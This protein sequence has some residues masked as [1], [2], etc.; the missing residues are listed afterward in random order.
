MVL[1]SPGSCDGMKKQKASKLS[2]GHKAAY[3]KANLRSKALS[4]LSPLPF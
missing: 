3:F 1:P 2:Q 4:K